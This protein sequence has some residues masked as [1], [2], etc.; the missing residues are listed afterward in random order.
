MH[1]TGP[2]EAGTHDL[3]G[4]L[5][6]GVVLGA[7][8]ATYFALAKG[9]LAL[10]SLHPSATP[11]WP[12][13][14]LAIALV[15]ILGY[16]FGIA[17]FAGAL[18]TNL[19][20]AGDAAS[21]IAIATGNTL[22]C[23]AAGYLI[24]RFADGRDAFDTPVGVVNFALAALVST[25]ISASIGV[26]AL[27]ATGF[28]ESSHFASIW[29]TW[30]LGDLGGAIVIAP[31]IMLWAR[32][33]KAPPTAMW[34]VALVYAGACVVGLLAFSPV[35]QQTATRGPLGFL[36]ILPL[37]WAALR[38]EQRDTATV[39]VIL[40]GFAVWGTVADGGPFV[41]TTLNDSF[42][43]LLAFM[44]SSVVPSLALSADAA[45]RRRIESDLRE[46]QA[47]L[48]QR[49]SQRTL[50]LAATNRRLQAEIVQRQAVEADLK[51]QSAHLQEAQR[52]ANLGSWVWDVRENSVRWSP[53]LYS[54]Y[55][56]SERDF[57]GTF[58]DFLRRIHPD[59]R[60]KIAREIERA[61]RSCSSF[62]LDERIVRPNGEVRYLQSVGEVMLDDA[63]DPAR[64]IGVCLDVTERKQAETALHQ[65]EEQYRL[66][67]D[68]IRDYSLFMLDPQG[69]VA[70]W[71]AG[72]A[73]I[74]QYAAHEII[75][76]HFS[77][78]YTDEERAA[79][80][81]ERA[82][83]IAATEGRYEA[84][85]WRVRKDGSR[86]WASVALDPIR[87]NEGTLI[88]FAKV[89]RDITERRQAQI[90]LEET[91]EQ[92]A[93][94]QKLEAIGQLTGGIAHD[95]NNL[96]MIVSGYAQVLA[97]RVSEP[98]LVRAIEAIQ[99]AAARGS[100][101]TRQLLAFS[102]R[103]ALSP[104]VVDL[105]AQLQNLREILVRTIPTNIEIK[106]AIAPD[107]WRTEVDLGE[108]ELA[109]VNIALNARDAMPDGGTLTLSARNIVLRANE[110]E[111]LA[112]D[113]IAVSIRD[114]GSG[115]EPD[116]LRR[117]FEPF[118]TT[119]AVGK[120]TG[121]G[122]SQVY[123]FAH[124]SGGAVTID[125]EPGTGTEVTIYLKRSEAEQSPE[126][127]TVN[128]SPQETDSSTILLIEDDEE[129]S[130]VNAMLLENL[131]Y[132]VLRAD[133]AA[134]ALQTLQQ[135]KSVDLILSDIVMPG[136]M[137]GIRLAEEVRERYP[138]IPVLLMS[139]YSD[140][141]QAA[142]GEFRILRKPF[143]SDELERAVREIMAAAPRPDR[144][145][146]Q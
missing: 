3:V 60:E 1:A 145:A 127:A 98:S 138:E 46:T 37:L 80:L 124:Q 82:L 86:F 28:A 65:T 39:A 92:L 62:R 26:G 89:T 102:R 117:V 110:V 100:N 113:Y 41:R 15:V 128:S 125:S 141:V 8:A 21:S 121:L 9:G 47:Q 91:R 44:I 146:A 27:T 83:Q 133:S 49:V 85:G 115:I 105:F 42:L 71:N 114:T 31:L 74:K 63:G 17:V 88:G 135:Q 38:C 96:L 78:F 23:L 6:T 144:T 136:A 36:A 90:A 118:F 51:L 13:T 14:G 81:P 130:A 73:R 134:H 2:Q 103:Q 93:Q 34:S 120:G 40:C 58:E 18:A 87:D 32:S 97:R 50:E 84:E 77:R 35:L 79:G 76:E 107:L 45:Q 109:L 69:R 59:D 30:W 19:T 52:L 142:R 139:G 4:W 57:A 16:R 24:N 54:I 116:V 56:I 94:A 99:S 108:F 131:G 20:I 106:S 101:L 72:A 66:M 33:A 112:G 75:G 48:H 111:G 126:T 61:F 123:G 11:I 140:A 122:L 25:M 29:L 12:P 70:T 129:V 68:S 143:D 5:K 10:A 7:A 95:F 67:V 53:E 43:L 64:M 132:R 137:N 104:V 55:G 119:K 22:E